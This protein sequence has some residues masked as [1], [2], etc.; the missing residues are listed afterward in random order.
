MNGFVTGKNAQV[1]CFGEDN[2]GA[3]YI[4]TNDPTTKNYKKPSGSSTW[5]PEI[6]GL[7][8]YN[9]YV[10]SQ[11]QDGTMLA[12][13]YEGLFKK[14]GG[15]WVG[16]NR[17][18]GA[19]AGLGVTASCFAVCVDSLNRLWAAY[20]VY[21]ASFFAI[22]T[23]VYYSTDAGNT[24]SSGVTDTVT[25]QKLVPM[26]D[27]VF[28]VSYY[29]GIYKFSSAGVL[30]LQ[31]I[32]LEAYPLNKGIKV[33]WK[34]GDAAGVKEYIIERSSEG[35]VFG[36]AGRQPAMNSTLQYSFFDQE[37]QR[38]TIFYR[39]RAIKQDGNFVYSSIVKVSDNKLQSFTVNPNPVKKGISLSFQMA[40]FVQ[41]TYVVRIFNS[42]GNT[43]S[44]KSIIHSGGSSVY[45]FSI[46]GVNQGIYF[47]KLEGKG[48]T[49]I[50]KILIE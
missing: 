24:W 11:L 2:S 32:N 10:W 13:C 14:V 34:V 17:P 6:N 47:I 20:N 41:G 49:I 5:E 48:Q 29:N 1:L 18:N 45:D 3:V 33:D 30:P 40:N 12:G 39:I 27:T 7:N 19:D 23:G 4:A 43:I 15:A 38:G 44:S 50:R 8:P 35:T 26:G 25:F 46:P 31:F 16:I 36:E 42:S 9:V 28:G 22:G 37:R 21:N